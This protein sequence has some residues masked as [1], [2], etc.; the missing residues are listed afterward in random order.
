MKYCYYPGCTL[1]NYAKDFDEYARKICQ[2]F[3]IELQ[4]ID[5]WQCCGG[6]YT[7]DNDVAKKL[8]SVRN[9]CYAK[10]QSLPLLTLCASCHNVIKRVNYDMKNNASVKQKINNYLEE[11]NSNYNGETNVVHFIEMLNQDVGFDKIKQNI[12]KPLNKKVACYYGCQL[13][14]PSKVMNF[15]N[16]ENPTIFQD[17]ISALGGIP[18]KFEFQNECCGSYNALTNTDNVK[19]LVL[20]ICNNA[21]EN[22]AEF[23]TT[24]CPLCLYNLKKYSPIPVVYFTQIMADCLGIKI[25]EE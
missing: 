22:G 21:I 15:D 20:K 24:T 5:E 2:K 14:R 13:L 23:I 25:K 4:E 6:L 9:L 16:P 17:L 11:T 1:K 3:D 10:D 8:A 12:L 18:V 7:N 19:N